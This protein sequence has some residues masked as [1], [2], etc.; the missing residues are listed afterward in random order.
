MLKVQVVIFVG[1]IGPDER[2]KGKEKMEEEEMD[3]TVKSHRDA[4]AKNEIDGRKIEAM[5][6]LSVR[7]KQGFIR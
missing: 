2:G 5:E 4:M 3:A 1:G 6:A 7:G